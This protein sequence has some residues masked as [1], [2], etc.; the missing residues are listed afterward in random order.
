MFSVGALPIRSTTRCRV[1]VALLATFTA[2][3]VSAAPA[4][5][6]CRGGSWPPARRR[7]ASRRAAK[8]R[9]LSCWRRISATRR[10]ARPRARLSSVTLFRQGWKRTRSRIRSTTQEPRSRTDVL[11]SPLSCRLEGAKSVLPYEIVEVTNRQV[12]SARSG[13][14]NRAR[15]AGAG[16]PSAS[17]DQA[18]TV[19]PR[20]RSGSNTTKWSLKTKVARWTPRR[21]PP[22]DLQARSRSTRPPTRT[23]PALVKDLHFE[24]PPGLVGNATAIPQCSELQ[25]TRTDVR[26]TRRSA[27]A[28]SWTNLGVWA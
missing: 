26:P 7:G 11:V 1:V 14:E 21:A 5:A 4:S 28:V 6:G 17:T 18:L 27:G 3:L 13:E 24:L 2:L 9:R 8:A 19:A 20:R 22:F 23:P 12:Q 10:R 15:I 25:F 16:A